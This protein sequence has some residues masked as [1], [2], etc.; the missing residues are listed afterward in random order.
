MSCW[1]QVCILFSASVVLA[2]VL[3][4]SCKKPRPALREITL[5]LSWAHLAQFAGP[6]Y[7]DQHGLYKKEGLQVRF[8][9]STIAHDPLEKLLAGEYDF[10]IA[11][12]DGV[13]RARAKGHG[14][15]AIAATYRIHPEEFLSLASS[16]IKTPADFR[17]KRIG[18]SYSER[19]ILET[20]LRRAGVDLR[21]VEIST[22]VHGLESLTSGDVDVQAGWVT[23]EVIAA[24]QR[25]L[26][27]NV[28]VP[29]DHGVTFYADLYTARDSLIANEPELVEKFLRATLRGWAAALQDPTEHSR[30]A[31]RHDPT[32]DVAHQTRILRAS[33]PLIHTGVNQIGWM[34]PEP[35][36]EMVEAVAGEED[37]PVRPLLEELFTM[38]FLHAIYGQR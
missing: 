18:V 34:L 27:V 17:G 7:A 37:L 6:Y 29:Y 35:W 24:E 5:G 19:L 36:K 12:P 22:R 32:L 31:L 4:P 8:V 13:I 20:M 9:P 10:V 14:V 25:G 16:G 30:L 33:A 15:T 2:T 1:K 28:I 21:D 3:S 11:Q 26:E 38:R 23:N